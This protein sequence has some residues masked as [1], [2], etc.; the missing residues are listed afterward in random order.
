[1]PHFTMTQPNPGEASRARRGHGVV[2]NAATAFV[3]DE[4]FLGCSSGVVS[5]LERFPGD[6]GGAKMRAV[7]PL[8]SR[9][10]CISIMVVQRKDVYSVQSCNQWSAAWR[11]LFLVDDWLEC[12]GDDWRRRRG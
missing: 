10:R 3:P 12:E 6:D 11:S 4:P 2:G 1:M 7:W 5:A 9:N 8:R